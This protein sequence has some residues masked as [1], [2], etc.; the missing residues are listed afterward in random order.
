MVVL[1]LEGVRGSFV[2]SVLVVVAVLL[3]AVLLVVVVVVVALLLLLL[4]PGVSYAV[5]DKGVVAVNPGVAN[6][7]AD[8]TANDGE[9]E[10]REEEEEGSAASLDCWFA[11]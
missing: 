6:A 11:C 7:E 10:E 8:G 3:V 1:L 4:T 5:L 2:E 9:E